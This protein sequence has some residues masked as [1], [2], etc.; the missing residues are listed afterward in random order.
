MFSTSCYLLKEQFK[1]LR[2]DDSGLALIY[3]TIAMPVIIGFGL[4]AVDVGRLSTLQSTLQHGADAL[5]LAGGGELDRRP[6]AIVRAN[7]AINNMMTANTNTSLF[8]TSVVDIRGSNVTVRYL[9]AIPGHGMN[10]TDADP[11]PGGAGLNLAIAADNTAARFIEV[12]VKPVTFNT[13][14]PASFLGASNAATS[15]AT[16]VAGFDAAVCNFTP[17]FMCNPFE[18]AT[19][20]T[21]VFADYGL[22]AH[23]A[24][25]ANKRRLIALKDHASGSQWSPGNYGFLDA[26]NG[27]KALKEAFA[28]TSPGSC[29]IQN[30]VTTKTGNI[31]SVKDAVNVRFD[32]YK[33]NADKIYP[34]SVNVRK[35]YIVWKKSGSPD[36]C[37]NNVPVPSG[38][39]MTPAY[40]AYN[41]VMGLP[42]DSCFPSSC[43][44]AGGRMG[45][46]DWGGD[47]ANSATVPDFEQYWSTN[48]GGTPRPR[49]SGGAFYS[50]TNLPTRYDI[51]RYEIA[52][53]LT[54]T[55]SAG[56]TISGT[57]FNE[58]G[59]PAC[60]PTN[61][62]DNPDRRILYG[63]ILNCRAAGL[64]SGASGGP[65]QSVAFGKFFI[66]EP[67]GDPPDSTL[68]TELI[69][70]VRP[71]EANS[72]ARDLVQL[73]R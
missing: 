6:D 54:A 40:P 67:M 55:A 18:P 65:Y 14:F 4:L 53:S 29:F 48:F 25:T 31:T 15:S 28:S 49:D 59:T 39:P 69:D 73:Y 50:N 38:E 42:Q 45:N 24:S 43:T 62:T 3:V 20:T 56:I 21:D 60:N 36:A 64:G 72:V 16:A 58:S 52:N 32:L 1:R 37:S 44:L 51:Y 61:K 23:I 22:Y 66:T 2:S 10:G 12:S 41:G 35:G 27:A 13:I 33:T 8:G 46:G 17:L 19:G 26:G 34:A 71:G 68:W 9:S 5:A 70:V 47:T 57:S 7:Y 63:A 11:M 30:G